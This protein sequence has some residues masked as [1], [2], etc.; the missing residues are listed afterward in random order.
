MTMSMCPAILLTNFWLSYSFTTGK[1]R[2]H[3]GTAGLDCLL[4]CSSTVHALSWEYALESLVAS[5]STYSLG[6]ITRHG[7][8][9]SSYLW[10]KGM[11]RG[12]C[13]WWCYCLFTV[14]MAVQKLENVV[15][16]RTTCLG[17]HLVLNHETCLL[18]WWPG[19]RLGQSLN[20]LWKLMH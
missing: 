13:S 6:E 18:V 7:D 2:I 5:D 4:A 3:L 10:K 20:I 15:T 1:S 17:I 8:M 19:E 11:Q 14:R 12:N 9:T 16:S